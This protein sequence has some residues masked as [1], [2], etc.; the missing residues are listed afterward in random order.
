LKTPESLESTA[1]TGNS[2]KLDGYA[3]YYVCEESGGQCLY[4]RQDFTVEIR[5]KPAK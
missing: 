2:I 1:A 3:L 5:F 4:L